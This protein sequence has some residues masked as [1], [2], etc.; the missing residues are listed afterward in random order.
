MRANKDALKELTE[1][2]GSLD[3]PQRY[4]QHFKR[5]DSAIDELY[6]AAQLAYNLVADPTA[7]PNPASKST[8]DMSMRPP[9][10]SS[11]PTKSWVG[12]TRRSKVYKGLTYCRS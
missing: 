3:P 12:T 11:D 7:A 4:R 9:L 8:T 5:F 2:V 1:Q 6:E 10:A